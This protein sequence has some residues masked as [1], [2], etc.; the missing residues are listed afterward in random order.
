M[1]SFEASF[2]EMLEAKIKKSVPIIRPEVLASYGLNRFFILDTRSAHEY[3]TSHLPGAIRVGYRDFDLGKLSDY[4]LD[5]CLLVYCSVG[6]RSEQ[7]GEKLMEAGY[8]KVF[9]LY[10]GI[11]GWKNQGRV[12][13]NDSEFPTERVHTYSEKWGQWLKTGEKVF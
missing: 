9:N 2:E 8:S 6:Y 5:S 12:I 7:V 13:L 4:P 1:T 11:F 10:G 3:D